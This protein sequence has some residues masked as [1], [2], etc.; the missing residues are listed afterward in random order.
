ML[1]SV[2]DD[3]KTNLLGLKALE[4][5]VSQ[6]ARSFCLTTINLIS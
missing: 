2:S 5:L 6:L 1:H 3:V 4:A